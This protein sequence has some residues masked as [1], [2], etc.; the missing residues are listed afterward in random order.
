MVKSLRKS[1]IILI[2]PRI[3]I[4]LIN[5]YRKMSWVLKK[6]QINFNF[7]KLGFVTQKS[8]IYMGHKFFNWTIQLHNKKK[9]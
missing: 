6:I 2:R 7:I 4:C 8:Q 5:F 9:G 3:K 1:S